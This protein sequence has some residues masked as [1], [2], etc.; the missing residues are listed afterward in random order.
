MHPGAKSSNE[1][2]EVSRKRERNPEQEERAPRRRVDRMKRDREE[3]EKMQV[4]SERLRERPRVALRERWMWT[5]Q[6]KWHG[7]K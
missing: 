2:S 4:K 3:I 5:V 7:R 1:G 6:M